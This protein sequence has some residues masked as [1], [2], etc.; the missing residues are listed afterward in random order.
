MKFLFLFAVSLSLWADTPLRV[1]KARFRPFRIAI[2]GSPELSEPVLKDLELSGVFEKS[3]PVVAEGTVRIESQDSQTKVF[4]GQ[5]VFKYSTPISEELIHQIASDTYQFFTKEKGFFKSQIAASKK[6]PRNKQ[7]VLMDFDGKN[8][9]ALS[10][11]KHIDILPTISPNGKEVFFTSYA[12]TNSDLFSTNINGTDQKTISAE[13]GINSGPSFSPDSKKIAL[14]LSLGNKADIYLLDLETKKKTR[15]TTGNSL[16]T[17][18]SFSPDGKQIAFVSNRSGSPQ[19][20]I[21]NSDGSNPERLTFLG[22]YNQSPKWSPTGQH[23]VF[24]GRDEHNIFDL[25]LINAQSK[26]ISRITQDQGSNEEASFAPNGRMIAFTSTRAGAR[27]IF[28]TNLDGSFQKQLTH[29][30]QYWT[31]FWGPSHD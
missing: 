8:E 16:N 23:I 25:Y 13:K 21:M 22:K 10:S 19:I 28:V 12:N 29:G 18:P 4:A 6:T 20:Y 14:T 9:K 1:E 24:T 27:D 15:L 7:I 2:T 5:S 30:G 3:I 11:G 17:S 26:N 31:P